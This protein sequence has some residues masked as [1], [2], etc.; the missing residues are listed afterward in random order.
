MMVQQDARIHPRIACHCT[1]KAPSASGLCPEGAALF[2]AQEHALKRFWA[3][4]AERWEDPWQ[5][6]RDHPDDGLRE[7]YLAMAMQSR[8]QIYAHVNG[9]TRLHIV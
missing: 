9:R 2:E 8:R 5:Y 6:E 7:Q 1:L 3:L 4:S